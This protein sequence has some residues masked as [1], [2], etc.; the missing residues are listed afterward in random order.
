MI[1]SPAHAAART[2]AA[3]LPALQ[4]SFARLTDTPG[5]ARIEIYDDADPGAGDVLVVI[6]MASGIGS[7]DEG[8]VRINLTAPI[9]GQ[10][11]KTGEALSARIF[12]GTEAWWADATVSNTSGSGEI[13][14]QDT[15][16]VVGAI[17]R[18][19]SA[20]FQG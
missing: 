20:H 18:L 15:A 6:E 13:K 11:I 7:I 9:E 1:L 14:L 17:A 16:L 10:I 4:A 3:R 12:D 5:P 2:E 8:Q 19:T